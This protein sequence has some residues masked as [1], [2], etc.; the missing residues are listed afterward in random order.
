MQCMVDVYTLLQDRRRNR[1]YT[2]SSH[3]QSATCRVDLQRTLPAQM[4]TCMR[5]KCAAC[6]TTRGVQEMTEASESAV[7]GEQLLFK[8][9]IA[10]FQ[11]RHTCT[12][13]YV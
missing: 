1:Q 11:T 5:C 13:C 8:A 3:A 7:T 12:H 9:S 10:S 2:G 6:N 4:L